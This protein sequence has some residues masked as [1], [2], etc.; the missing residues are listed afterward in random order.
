MGLI[1]AAAAGLRHSQSNAGSESHMRPTP[2]LKAVPLSKARDRTYIL[3]D[4]H[5]HC[6]TVGTPTYLF[7]T[8]KLLIKISLRNL[9]SKEFPSRLS[10]NEPN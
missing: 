3:M 5:F 9:I 8:Q 1:G 7:V 4:T 10:S 6:P 2:Q